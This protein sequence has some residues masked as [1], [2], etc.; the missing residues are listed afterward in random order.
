MFILL[1]NLD[2]L[3]LLHE[4]HFAAHGVVV[5]D[6]LVVVQAESGLRH[7][8]VFQMMQFMSGTD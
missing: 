8:V 6:R 1:L 7:P 3:G 2:G 5:Q 4:A